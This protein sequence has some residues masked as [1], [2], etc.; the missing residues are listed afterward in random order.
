MTN[1]SPIGV[2]ILTLLTGGIYG[3][4]WLYW[5]KQE[6]ITRGAEI[7]TMWLIWIPF[8]SIYWLWKWSEGVEKATSTTMSSASAFLLCWLLGGIGYAIVQTKFNELAAAA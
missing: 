7:P 3:I 8:I 5:T 2:F 6:M 4:F 1:R